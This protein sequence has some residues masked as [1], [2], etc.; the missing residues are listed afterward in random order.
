[1][2]Y[3]KISLDEYDENAFLECYIADK[4]EYLTRKAILVIP[5][6]AYEHVSTRE[7]EPV[8]FA[9][10]PYGYNAF[11]LHYSVKKYPFPKHLIQASMAIKHIKDNA[12]EYGIDP[13]EVFIV[14]FSAGGHLAGSL[15]TM[16][17]NEEIY[18]EVPMDVG[19]NK[20]KGAM[21][22]YPVING[23]L[24]SF[25][26]LLLK[27]DV[28]DEDIEK[29]SIANF[30][31]ENSCPMF[32]FHTSNDSHV[33][34]KNS[35]DLANRL[36]EQNIKFELHVFPDAPHGGALYNETTSDAREEFIKPRYSE[37][38]KMATDWANEL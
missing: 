18:K 26:N 28:T 24:G 9:F 2:I 11:V 10:M 19:Y 29:H 5:G 23:H 33:P 3:K 36:A 31:N 6:G 7:G 34:V 13:E 37:W 21:L 15:A 16:W 27:E 4:Q 38:V 17:D 35:L 22:I 12:E 8:A 25:K 32:I 20:P 1:M 30:V 14:G